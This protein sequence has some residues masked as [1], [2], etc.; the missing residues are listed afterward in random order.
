MNR[1]RKIG[2]HAF[3]LIELLVVIAIIALL[4]GILLPAMGKAKMAA[5]SM[6]EQATGHNQTTAWAA[7]YTDM[8]DRI[9]PGECHWA[10]NHLHSYWHYQSDMFP[11]LDS[12]RW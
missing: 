1:R 10:W 5:K 4:I 9:L 8:R 7:Y 2:T 3:T 6:Q 12:Q 11:M